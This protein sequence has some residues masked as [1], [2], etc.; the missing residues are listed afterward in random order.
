MRRAY[1]TNCKVLVDLRL[2]TY[3]RL[4]NYRAV[5]EGYC[6][7]C[8]SVL[9]NTRVMPT[10]SKKPMG[11]KRRRKKLSIYSYPNRN[12]LWFNRH[13]IS[14]QNC[15]WNHSNPTETT[16][17]HQI[18][19]ISG[20]SVYDQLVPI[21]Y[22]SKAIMGKDNREAIFGLVLESNTSCYVIEI[23]V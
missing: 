19:S 7:I 10:S 14:K 4:A 9:L 20:F 13:H 8:N 1:C 5:I 21:W 11:N 18:W 16:T 3:V 17:I 12:L 15:I 6:P 2:S 23:M 22:H